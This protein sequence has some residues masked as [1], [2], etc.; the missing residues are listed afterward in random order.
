[1]DKEIARSVIS[2]ALI[3]G[4]SATKILLEILKIENPKE[5]EKYKNIVDNIIMMTTIDL[6]L[7]IE[8]E[9]PDLNPDL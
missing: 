1:M 3:C 4:Q 5:K 7:S 2:D 8:K 9:Y 6:I